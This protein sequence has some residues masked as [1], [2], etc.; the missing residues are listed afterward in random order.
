MGNRPAKEV[1]M[2]DNR[3][4]LRQYLALRSLKPRSRYDLEELQPDR[5][6]LAERAV[7][8]TDSTFQLYRF[9]TE[10]GRSVFLVDRGP[11][12]RLIAEK[13]WDFE[14]AHGKDL[15]EFFPAGKPVAILP[16]GAAL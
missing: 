13:D 7:C 6:I 12:S 9:M 14:L 10:E 4:T 2:A 16:K 15:Q 8:A 11:D 1:W 3:I 5:A